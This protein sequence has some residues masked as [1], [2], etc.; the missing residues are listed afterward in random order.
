MFNLLQRAGSAVVSEP[1]Y[2]YIRAA[3]DDDAAYLLQF[4]ET[5]EFDVRE[6]TVLAS[7][8]ELHPQILELLKA[9]A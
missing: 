3:S 4:A 8:L 1:L 2:R 7:N 5:G 9:A 6:G